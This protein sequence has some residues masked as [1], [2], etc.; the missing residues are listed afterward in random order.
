MFES[1]SVYGIGI[2]S[3]P[4]LPYNSLSLSFVVCV[5]ALARSFVLAC[6]RAFARAC[7]CAFAC[8]CAFVCVCVCVSV[9]VLA[10]VF[11][12]LYD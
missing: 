7:L 11:V 3:F 9:S 5:R 6:L 12:C 8:V 2:G 10:C 1:A 4:A